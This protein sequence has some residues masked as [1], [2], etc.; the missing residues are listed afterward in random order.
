M[1]S[2]RK[3]R[4]NCDWI[5]DGVDV[6]QIMLNCRCHSLWHQS[7]SRCYASIIIT[8]FFYQ[9][10]HT[11]R[12]LPPAEYTNLMSSVKLSIL[13]FCQPSQLINIDC[14]CFSVLCR[15]AHPYLV[16]RFFLFLFVWGCVCVVESVFYQFSDEISFVCDNLWS[17]RQFKSIPLDV[18]F[19]STAI[20]FAS[21]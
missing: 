15:G 3:Q 4:Q 5:A 2:I 20:R 21:I 19:I 13:T 10:F 17:G 18:L 1:K 14:I 7:L 9:L 16:A 11:P 12:T 6:H 8:S